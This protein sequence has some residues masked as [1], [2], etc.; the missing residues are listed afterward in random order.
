MIERA[1]ENWLTSTNE[2]NYQ[3]AFCQILML[4]GYKVVYNSSHHPMEFGKDV[5]AID[6]E[7]ACCAYQLKTGDVSL[8]EWRKIW[9]EVQ[10]LIEIPPDHPSVDKSK[11]HKAFLV[12]NGNVTDPV[13]AQITQRNDDNQRKQ[14]DCAYLD[15]INKE[16]LLQ[17]FIEAQGHFIPT[18]VED[19]D[20]FLKLFQADGTD[21][22]EK[23]AF[24]NF[25]NNSFF[26]CVPKRK[27]DAVSAIASSVIIT[28]YVLNSFQT[29]Q[30]YFALFEA[31][32]CLAGCIARFAFRCRQ[33]LNIKTEDWAE[34]YR[35]AVSECE[36]SLLELKEEAL[37]RENLIEGDGMGDGA[38]VYR[39]RATMLFGALAALELNLLETTP[40][41]TLDTRVTSFIEENEKYLWFWGD[42]A[43]PFFFSLIRFL[44]LSGETEKAEMRLGEVF[45]AVLRV[46]SRSYEG[47]GL[48]SPY[49]SSHEILECAFGF[50]EKKLDLKNFVGTSYVLEILVEMLARRGKREV[51][52]A[53]WRP[54]SRVHVNRFRFDKPEDFFSWFAETGENSS[55][56]LQQTQSWADLVK[57]SEN[58]EKCSGMWMNHSEILLYWILALPHRA[59]T[60]AI[61]I[62]DR[63]QI[64]A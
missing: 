44:E 64:T 5:V 62:L 40:S 27:S 9:G 10:E 1:I 18:E 30:N 49:Y 33:E 48:A 46:N 28:A 3:V 6:P 7:G 36:A 25:I 57:Q 59:N 51:L 35:L 2:R 56:F 38:L 14:R 41:Y 16:S 42:S 45:S 17:M 50:D 37:A 60:D 43:F 53:N 58:L 61:R 11:T 21:F 22:L 39:A 4:K 8:G 12:T 20:S 52:E 19:F 15:I 29:R 34:S 24:F 55:Y 13:R 63:E 32:T 26:G 47:E 31:W 54:I 23:E